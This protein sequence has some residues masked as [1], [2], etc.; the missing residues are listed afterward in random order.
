M[1]T[2]DNLIVKT[3]TRTWIAIIAT[4]AGLCTAAAMGYS[5][6]KTNV[7]ENRRMMIQMEEDRKEERRMRL[8]DE[9]IRNLQIE[10]IRTEMQRMQV[11][12]AIMKVKLGI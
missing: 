5:D 9:E 10:T 8:K 12:I 11:D 4:V 6:I 3:T 2:V 7:L 1:T